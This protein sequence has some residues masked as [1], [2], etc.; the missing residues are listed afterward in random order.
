MTKADILSVYGNDLEQS[1]IDRINS[2]LGQDDYGSYYV[3]SAVP[4]K[5]DDAPHPWTA[6]MAS[7]NDQYE[8]Y[9]PYFIPVYEVEWIETDDNFVM[10]RYRTVRIGQDIYINYGLDEDVVRTH[11]NPS[12]CT[13]SVNGMYLLNRSNHPYSMVLACGNLQDIYNLLH[14]YRDNLIANSGSAGD[15]VDMSLLPSFLG[16]TPQ[17]RLLKYIGYKKNGLALLDSSQEGRMQTGEAPVNTIFNGYDDTVKGQA[18]QAIELAIQSTENECSSITGVFKERLNG[19]QQR[20][21]VTNVQTSVNNSYTITKQYSQQ[22]DCI[23]EEMLLDSLNVAKRVYSNG[24]TGTIVLGD[25]RNKL[26]TS[27][28]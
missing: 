1:D 26:F 22:M 17:E 4:I 19:I 18:V 5:A 9:N 13:I 27:L 15:F 11:D 14:F 3:K 25:F 8:M 7:T 10:Q 28:P 6:R 16:K 12:A 21:A 2:R 24:K 23:M 20:D